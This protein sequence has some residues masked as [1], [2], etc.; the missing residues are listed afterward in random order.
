MADADRMLGAED[1]GEQRMRVAV[2]REGGHADAVGR[3]CLPEPQ[4]VQARHGVQPRPQATALATSH[5]ATIATR[6]RNN[7]RILDYA[8]K[9]SAVTARAELRAAFEGLT[10][11]RAAITRDG[12]ALS[13]GLMR[14]RRPGVRPGA[15]GGVAHDHAPGP[16]AQPSRAQALEDA[17]RLQVRG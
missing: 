6:T 13:A 3:A 1:G 5:R 17:A 16:A 7:E 15:A 4:R 11:S 2:E 12:V 8:E 9:L 10:R 14:P